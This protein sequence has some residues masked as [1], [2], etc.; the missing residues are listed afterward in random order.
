MF[1]KKFIAGRHNAQQL[2]FDYVVDI[3]LLRDSEDV[4]DGPIY[5]ESRWKRKEQKSENDREKHHYFLLHGVT[6][7]WGQLLLYEHGSTH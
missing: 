3:V 6:H 5:N 7:R 1:T 4:V 2:I